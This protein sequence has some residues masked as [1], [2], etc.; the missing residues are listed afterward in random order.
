MIALDDTN[1]VIGV[2]IVHMLSYGTQA[3]LIS[4]RTDAVAAA[5]QADNAGQRRPP[6]R[7]VC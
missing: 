3:T 2:R 6:P 5:A 7:R 1:T 4:T